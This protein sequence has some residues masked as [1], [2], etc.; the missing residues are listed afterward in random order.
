MSLR[1]RLLI[2]YKRQKVALGLPN[3]LSDRMTAELLLF[4]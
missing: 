2:I 3:V 4:R 1:H